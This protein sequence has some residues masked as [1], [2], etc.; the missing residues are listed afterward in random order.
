MDFFRRRRNIPTIAGFLLS[1]SEHP[2]PWLT[3]KPASW[4]QRARVRYR[5]TTT[6]HLVCG[7]FKI[8]KHG[9]PFLRGDPR[10]RER[11]E[12]VE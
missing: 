4:G 7:P 6:Q 5:T 3:L 12:V 2:E 11:Y 8:R 10:C 9:V 1:G